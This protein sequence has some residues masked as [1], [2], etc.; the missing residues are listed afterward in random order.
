M[1][2]DFYTVS[3]DCDMIRAD[4]ELVGYAARSW[5]AVDQ[6]GKP[7]KV[8]QQYVTAYTATEIDNLRNQG[9]TMRPPTI[10]V[11]DVSEATER[12]ICAAV[13]DRDKHSLFGFAAESYDVQRPLH[14][15]P[16]IASFLEQ[17]NGTATA[18]YSTAR[19]RAGIR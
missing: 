11:G 1:R 7:L 6:Y 19:G 14:L 2:I 13:A 18:R 12:K 15:N 5:H 8:R 16:V 9:F 10:K 17:Q 4:G 3:T